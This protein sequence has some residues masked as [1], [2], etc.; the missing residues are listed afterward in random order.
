MVKFKNQLQVFDAAKEMS[1]EGIFIEATPGI[2]PF[3]PSKERGEKRGR[4]K[5]NILNRRKIKEGHNP[6]YTDLGFRRMLVLE[7]HRDWLRNVK[8]RENTK[9]GDLRRREKP[10]WTVYFA[11]ELATIL[12][13]RKTPEPYFQ[14]KWYV[15]KRGHFVLECVGLWHFI[16][17]MVLDAK[18]R[19]KQKGPSPNPEKLFKTA[20]ATYVARQLINPRGG[21]SKFA[22]TPLEISQ[23]WF[24]VF[25]EFEKPDN[26]KSRMRTVGQYCEAF[27]LYHGGRNPTRFPGLGKAIRVKYGANQTR[28]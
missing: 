2:D 21:N 1:Q 22:P 13:G 24:L 5:A 12:M 14:A 26:I 10:I 18:Y 3:C 17:R 20:L 6:S 4:R 23:A 28:L 7:K 25:G 27:P 9:S 15:E 19:G 11:A 8:H 16:N